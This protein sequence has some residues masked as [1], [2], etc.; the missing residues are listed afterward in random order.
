MIGPGFSPEFLDSLVDRYVLV[1]SAPDY[2]QGGFFRGWGHSAVLLETQAWSVT[3]TAWQDGG[4]F[5]RDPP[6]RVYISWSEITT[7]KIDNTRSK[8]DG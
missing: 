7:I 8:S 1:Y 3:L 4:S 2:F 5:T 6:E